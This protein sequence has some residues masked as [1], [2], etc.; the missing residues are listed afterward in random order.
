MSKLR[1]LTTV[2]TGLLL[3]VIG[4]LAAAPTAFAMRVVPP[5][6]DSGPAAPTYIVTQTGMTGW[7]VALIAIC[8]ALAAVALTTI[9]VLVRFRTRLHPAAG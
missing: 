8:A 4:V 3:A 5:E 2:L 7:Q 6:G 9:V 1:R